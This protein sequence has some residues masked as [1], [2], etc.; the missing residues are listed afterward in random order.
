M[1]TCQLNATYQ[2]LLTPIEEKG[3]MKS[4]LLN[5]SVEVPFE[6]FLKSL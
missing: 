5:E 4:T 2:V 6:Y 1:Q 3:K